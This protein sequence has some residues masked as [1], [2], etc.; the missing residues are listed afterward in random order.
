MNNPGMDASLIN[1][2]DRE[3]V[4]FHKHPVLLH[5]LTGSQIIGQ[6]LLV[7]QGMLPIGRMQDQQNYPA[8]TRYLVLSIY[9]CLAAFR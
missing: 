3:S 5:Y 8:S 4:L 9:V 7:D 2:K 1:Y 6:L